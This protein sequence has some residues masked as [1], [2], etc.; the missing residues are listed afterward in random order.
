M[1]TNWIA[2][3]V[4]AMALPA[5]AQESP[6]PQQLWDGLLTS[7]RQFVT[8]TLVYKNLQA[9]RDRTAEKQEPRVAI[10]SCADSRVP[11]ELIFNRSIG[12]LFIVRAAGNIADDFGV[13]S[14]EYAV[15]NGWTKLLVV[16]GHTDCGA[17]KEALTPRH[18][19]PLTPALDI[20]L[21][22]IRASFVGIPFDPKNLHAATEAN[23]RS[24]AAHLLADSELLRMAVTE[25]RVMVVTAMY[26]LKTGVVRRVE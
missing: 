18:D 13:A 25:N 3:A 24:S 6:S 19:P 2:L 21:A 5:L 23:T 7:N 1:R 11:P 14:L 20:L 17:V 9:D 10:L 26:D 22:R 4:V 16:L 8:G 15:A 12:D